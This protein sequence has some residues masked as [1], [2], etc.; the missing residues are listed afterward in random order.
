MNLVGLAAGLGAGALW[1]LVF[2]APRML[3]GVSAI[4]LANGRFIAYGVVA[5]LVTLFMRAV[6]RRTDVW[7]SWAQFGH[8]LWLSFLGFGGYYALLA[9]AIQLAGTDVPSLII[10]TIPLALMLLGRPAG[11]HLRT[12]LPA[13]LL[14]GLG[15]VLMMSAGHASGAA[16][17]SPASRGSW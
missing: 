3:P 4:D 14:T 10:G 2:V 17:D 1:G 11:M 12:V 9:A 15:L 7:P 5:F 16:T 8:A 13:L 6:Q